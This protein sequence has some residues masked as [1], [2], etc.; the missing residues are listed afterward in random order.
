MDTCYHLNVYFTNNMDICQIRDSHSGFAE[1]SSP[2]GNDGMS[3]GVQFPIFRRSEAPSPS[4]SISP[5]RFVGWN[6]LRLLHPEDDRNT[7]LLNVVNYSSSDV[8]SDP[9]TA[10][11]HECILISPSASL[12]EK[13]SP[14]AFTTYS[15]KSRQ[16]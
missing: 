11:S 1:D 2:L 12:R 10:Y 13:C 8:T 14:A 6:Q 3:S 9:R 16:K 15:E 5:R 7:I 4:R